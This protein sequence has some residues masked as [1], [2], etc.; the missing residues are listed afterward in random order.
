MTELFNKVSNN[1]KS[2][3]KGT[4]IMANGDTTILDVGE[5]KC[6]G[7][8]CAG[9]TNMLST[10]DLYGTI[11]CTI[12]DASCV[13]N[14]ESSRRG[15]W[16]QGTDSGTL[17]LRAIRFYRGK[18]VAGGG[19]EVLNNAIVQVV[20]CVFDSCQATDTGRGG[21]GICVGHIGSNTAVNIYATT[22]TG[23]SAPDGKGKDIRRTGGNVNLH[24][25][26]CPSPYSAITPTQGKYEN[27]P[28]IVIDCCNRS[29]LF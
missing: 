6:S 15:M 17:T 28:H 7:A 23:N 19:L 21:G 12:D 2:N 3:N 8:T 11:R 14:G 22:F 18:D 27:H 10:K 4:S 1:D 26:A 13:L 5:Y 25:N 29:W 24:N 16:V 20:L 9:S